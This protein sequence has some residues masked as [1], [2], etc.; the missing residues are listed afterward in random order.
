MSRL[1]FIG[2]YA[3]PR[4][5]ISRYNS[6]L[7]IIVDFASSSSRDPQNATIITKCNI[8]TRVIP[9]HQFP[10]HQTPSSR[11]ETSLK[12]PSIQFPCTK[13]HYRFSPDAGL[14]AKRCKKRVARHRNS[15]IQSELTDRSVYISRYYGSGFRFQIR[16][17][18]KQLHQTTASNKCVCQEIATKTNILPRPSH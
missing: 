3:S 15:G 17:D 13:Y 7:W 14:Q 6:H 16:K 11:T 5:H 8:F 18:V 10:H 1:C 9:P 2:N 12:T 4:F